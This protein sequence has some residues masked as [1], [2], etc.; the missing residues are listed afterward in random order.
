M[1]RYRPVRL[2]RPSKH[3]TPLRSDGGALRLSKKSKDFSDSLKM[4]I[5]SHRCAAE[6]SSLR[7]LNALPCKAFRAFDP[8]RGGLPPPRAPPPTLGRIH[9]N[10]GFLTS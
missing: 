6:K 10:R 4:P 1:D 8:T 9:L 2:Q 3:T 5:L 7:S